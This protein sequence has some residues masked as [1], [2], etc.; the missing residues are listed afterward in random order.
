MREGKPFLLIASN[1]KEK[2]HTD[3]KFHDPKFRSCATWPGARRFAYSPI[4]NTS[5]ISAAK[6]WRE[7]NSASID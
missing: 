7:G 1:E 4:T 6:R 3:P 2:L 5:S